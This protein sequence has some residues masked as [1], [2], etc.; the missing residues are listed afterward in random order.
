M[1]QRSAEIFL[2]IV[3]TLLLMLGAMALTFAVIGLAVG[4]VQPAQAPAHRGV[5]LLVVILIVGGVCVAGSLAIRRVVKRLATARRE[6][7]PRG[8]D[9]LPPQ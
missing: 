9:V 7:R 8:F 1:G 6:T 4:L 2:T 5:L 3:G